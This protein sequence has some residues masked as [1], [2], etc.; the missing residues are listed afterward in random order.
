MRALVVALVVA[1]GTLAAGCGGSSNGGAPTQ[2][3]CKDAVGIV[4]LSWTIHRQA[5]TADQ[6]CSGVANLIVDLRSDCNEV[7]IEPVPCTSGMRWRYDAL[8]AGPQ[9]V[10]VTAVDRNDRI[11]AQGLGEATLDN[12]VPTQPLAIDLQ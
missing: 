9:T 6:G 7:E 3:G 5:P 4:L 11:V 12:S 8:P 10:T 2:P 1:S